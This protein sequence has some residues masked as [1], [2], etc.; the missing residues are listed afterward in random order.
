MTDYSRLCGCDEVS[1][2]RALVLNRGKSQ[3]RT[4][5]VF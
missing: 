5:T 4:V 3:S 2:R 1:I